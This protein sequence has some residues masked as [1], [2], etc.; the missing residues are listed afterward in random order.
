MKIIIIIST[1]ND[2]KLG[3]YVFINLQK[4]IPD[5]PSTVLY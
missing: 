4:F 2:G 3:N 1:N 5:E